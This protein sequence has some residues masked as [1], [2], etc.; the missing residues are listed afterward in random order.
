VAT[1]TPS[2]GSVVVVDVV[3]SMVGGGLL[4]R[5]E[6]SSPVDA[7]IGWVL[8]ALGRSSEVEPVLDADSRSSEASERSATVDVEMF[9]V[10]DWVGLDS[11]SNE[12]VLAV[13]S[14]VGEDDSRSADVEGAAGG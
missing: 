5:A 2:S 6:S 4:L 9:E 10:P 3:P 1:P 7:G 8:P 11:R 12:D 14:Q 13:R